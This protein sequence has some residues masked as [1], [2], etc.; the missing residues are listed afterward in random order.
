MI[1]KCMRSFLCLFCY[2][3][4]K[5]GDLCFAVIVSMLKHLMQVQSLN[6]PSTDE[7]CKVVDSFQPNFVYLQGEHLP[8]DEVGS[9]VWGDVDLST[10]DAMSGLFNVS[11]LPTTVCDLI[12]Y[13]SYS[14]F[15]FQFY[16]P[17]V[18]YFYLSLLFGVRKESFIYSSIGS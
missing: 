7:F 8:N 12:I 9:L 16:V 14:L 6:N 17:G 1:Y 11:T 13:F 10:S 5:L 3:V 18:V 4:S 2:E 15:E